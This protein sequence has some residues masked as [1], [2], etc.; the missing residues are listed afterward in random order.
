MLIVAADEFVYGTLVYSFA[1]D[2][3]PAVR[4]LV[5]PFAAEIGSDCDV[6]VPPLLR[7]FLL[8]GTLSHFILGYLC[9]ERVAI[10]LMK[11]DGNRC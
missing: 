4:G 10:E 3:C 6:R 5:G 11:D 9:L 2:G 1:L 8:S 7:I